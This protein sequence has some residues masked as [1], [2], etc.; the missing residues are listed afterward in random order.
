M[1]AAGLT[2]YDT[3]HAEKI[4]LASH[5]ATAE[6]CGQPSPL[7]TS[8]SEVPSNDESYSNT[9]SQRDEGHHE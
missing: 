5:A 6:D 4:P 1:E 3:Q 7:G 8:L 9:A 2:A